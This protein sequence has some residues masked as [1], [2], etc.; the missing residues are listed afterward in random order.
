MSKLYR[1]LRYDWPLHFV[2]LLTNWLPDNVM[3]IR[4]RGIL[5]RPFFKKCGRKLSIGRNVTF[6]DPSKIEIGNF[7]YFS[8]GTWMSAGYGIVIEDEVL[9]GPYAVVVTSDHTMLAGSY[10]YGT[11][12][13][14]P[15]VIGKGTWL[16]AHVTVLRG[17]RIGHGCLIAANT[18]VTRSVEP[19]SVVGGVPGRVIKMSTDS[20]SG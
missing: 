18:V 1:L 19:F 13:G 10:R 6:Y 17:I 2:L 4:L 14:A 8:L 3:F 15:V 12:K 20:I 11:P 5:A 16:G 9:F 7:V